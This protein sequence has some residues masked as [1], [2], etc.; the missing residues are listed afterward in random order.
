MNCYSPLEA[1][2]ISSAGYNCSIVRA[3]STF[4]VCSRP[5]PGLKITTERFASLGLCMRDMRGWQSAL[6]VN[7]DIP[8]GPSVL[9]LIPL[10]DARHAVRPPVRKADPLPHVLARLVT[11]FIYPLSRD[12]EGT[13]RLDETRRDRHL[14]PKSSEQAL[15]YASAPAGA[16]GGD[17]KNQSSTGELRRSA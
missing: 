7:M 2:S 4:V 6:T 16:D 10:P 17:R 5:P 14:Q 8:Q 15:S 1:A 3:A 13:R 11:R 9:V 12:K